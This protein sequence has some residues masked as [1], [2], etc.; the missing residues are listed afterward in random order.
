MTLDIGI[1]NIVQSQG[2]SREPLPSSLSSRILV[3]SRFRSSLGFSLL[4]PTSEQSRDDN[5]D[6]EHCQSYETQREACHIKSTNE[7][8]FPVIAVSAHASIL[9]LSA[10]HSNSDH[11]SGEQDIQDN[12]Y[13]CEEFDSHE[14]E[15]QNCCDDAVDGSC[16]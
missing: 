9:S 12:P 3:E 10:K 15:S 5:V 4:F 16:S 7:V 13:D 1:R 14:T 2:G 8:S 11:A 6:D